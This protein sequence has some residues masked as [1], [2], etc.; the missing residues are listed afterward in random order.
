[1]FQ[2]DPRISVCVGQNTTALAYI[3]RG[4]RSIIALELRSHLSASLK[5]PPN[6]ESDLSCVYQ[7]VNIKLLTYAA[8]DNTYR[9]KVEKAPNGYYS[10]GKLT[11][12]ATDLHPVKEMIL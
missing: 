12:K 11:N 7:K 8:I 5:K 3:W 9:N 1:M 4:A 10:I 2:Q 6:R